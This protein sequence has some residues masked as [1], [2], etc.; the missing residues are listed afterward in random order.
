MHSKKKTWVHT[1]LSVMAKEQ[2]IENWYGKIFAGDSHVVPS[3]A[4]EWKEQQKPLLKN[5]HL[6]KLHDCRFFHAGMDARVCHPET[7]IINFKILVALKQERW[8]S[9]QQYLILRYLRL[10]IDTRPTR[11]LQDLSMAWIRT[12]FCSKHCTR[13]EYTVKTWG[14]VIG[15]RVSWRSKTSMTSLESGGYPL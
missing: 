1:I 8:F 5:N 14:G 4:L 3:P 11:E 13:Q 9:G 15:M 10:R 2:P 6:C 7:H 12:I